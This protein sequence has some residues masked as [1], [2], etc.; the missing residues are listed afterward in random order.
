[1]N[2]QR[3]QGKSLES[4]RLETRE[5]LEAN[6]PA[7]MRGR[8]VH[9]EDAF[10][11]YNTDDARLWLQRAA[12]RG[13][14]APGWP[15]EYGGGGLSLDEARVLG[16]EMTAIRAL[17]PS[18]GMGLAMIG[19]TLL[20]FGTAEQKQR[21]LPRIVSG[22]VRWCQGYSEPGSGSDLASLRTRAV[23]EGD[24]FV[25][26][27][28][29]IWTSGADHADWMFCLVR[30][31]PDAPKHDGISFVLL[32]MKQPGVTI[33]PIRLISGSSPFCETFLDNA[34]ARKEDLIGELN[35]GWTVAKR[36]L[37]YERSGPGDSGAPARNEKPQLNVYARIAKDYQ[38]EGDGKLADASVRER[39]TRQLMQE[40]SLQLTARR[41]AEES[42]ST[43][44]PGAATSIFKYVGST[45]A[46]DGSELKAMLRGTR[47]L[48]WDGDAFT[49]AELES[50]RGWLRDR[51]VT[52]YGGTNE[53]QLNIIAKRVLGLPE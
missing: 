11:I 6:C 18:T 1:M 29:K 53:V 21:H 3:N 12:E 27:G 5:W 30:T 50:T 19:P 49:D 14:T 39:I 32:E 13:W 33:K 23:L 47:G 15:K 17:P 4:F 35:K 42:R 45:L 48:G 46:K 41:V 44:A 28:Q 8:S 34:I 26:N 37:Q 22:E 31:D 2:V 38:G 51:A 20:E 7:S 9:F 25:I 36:L 40:K 10:D 24:H 52:I 43:G 16:Q